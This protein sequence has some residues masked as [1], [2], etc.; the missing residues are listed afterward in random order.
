[1]PDAKFESG[2]FSTFGDMTSEEGNRSLNFAIY[3]RKKGLT[4]IKAVFESRIVLL[5][6]KL[7]P[8]PM[9]IS[10]IFKQRK[11]FSFS[12]LLRRLS[13]KK[14]WQPPPSAPIDQFA[15]I[16]LEHV[17]KIKTKSDNVWGSQNERFLNGSCEFGHPGL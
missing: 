5:D 6:P 16:W 7:N 14:K 10:A 2:S 17:L 9:S 8:N 11:I 15:K 1:M 12:K 13:E 3:P 4:L